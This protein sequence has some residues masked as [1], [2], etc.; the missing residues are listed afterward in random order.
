MATL[1]RDDLVALA[2]LIRG[3]A[4]A[5]SAPA[6]PAAAS[7]FTVV[8]GART[9]RDTR[10]AIL[11]DQPTRDAAKQALSDAKTKQTNAQ[12]AYESKL[13]A[14]NQKQKALDDLIASGADQAAVLVIPRVETSVATTRRTTRI[15][16]RTLS[17][18]VVRS[19]G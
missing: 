11:R 9:S 6:A 15:G 16:S 10:P 7:P 12:T 4:P 19:S 5:E 1:D 13:T 14:Q 18:C 3:D 8:S 2:A 17:K